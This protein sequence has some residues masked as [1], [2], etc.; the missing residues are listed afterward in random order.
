MKI[1][2]R[3][4]VV[5]CLLM[6]ICIGLVAC[7]GGECSHKWGDWSVT[8]N[9]TCIESGEKERKCSECGKTETSVIEAIGHDW[10]EATCTSPKT[11]KNCSATEGSA[12][13]HTYDQEV[14]KAEALKSEATCSSAAVYYKSCSCG[15]ISKSEADTFTSGSATAHTY[16]IEV[17]KAEALK[18]EATCSGAAVYYKSCSCGAISTSEADTF[19]SGSALNHSYAKISSTA[20][21]CDAPATETYRCSCG[22]E[23]TDTIGDALGHDIGGVASTEKQISGCEY[24]LMYK[25][26]R[27]G[28]GKKVE[29]EHIYRHS[30]VASITKAATCQS[31]GEKTLTCSSCG[32]SVKEAIA[33]DSTGHNWVKG[34]A[35][36][37]V[38]T[39]ECSYC[40]MTKNVAVY[41]GTKTDV[42]NAND[43]KNTEIEL[44]NANISLGDGVVD[45][46][47]DKNVTV[48]ADKLEGDDRNI[49]G[50]S[51]EQLSQVGNNPIYNFTINDGTENISQFGENNYVT[52]TLPYALSEGEDV[53]SIAVWF[54]G[55]R[56][57]E[58]I[59]ATYN[60]GYVT[61]KTNHFSYYTVTRLTPKE[62]CALYG[63]SYVDRHVDGSCTK[64]AY[65]LFVCVRCH[66]KYTDNLVEADG[67]DYVPDA[68]PATCTENGYTTYT[69]DDCGHS[70]T[71]RINATGH[72]WSVEESVDATCAQNGYTK[73]GCDNCEEEYTV[74]YDK[75]AHQFTDV[76]VPATCIKDGYTLH[77][78][79]NCD[80]SF[81]DTY[82]PAIGH[83][84]APYDWEWA[85]DYSSA[86]LTLVCENDDEHE[87][88]L[89]ASV[90]K[91]VVSGSCSS[92]VKTTFTATVTYDGKTYTDEKGMEEGTPSHNFSPE[93]KSNGEEHWHE[94][95]C[96]AKSDVSEHEF[97]NA[98]VT[99]APTCVSEG[100]STSY[101]EC[102]ETKVT[103]LPATNEHNYVDGICSVCGQE[104]EGCDHT[105]LH[106][107]SVD[108]GEIGACDFIF[109][110]ETCSCGEVKTFD[111]YTSI[112]PCKFGEPEMK[113]YT[114]ENGNN[115]MSMKQA[116]E[117][118]GLEVSATAVIKT[119]GCAMSGVMNCTFKLNG[120]VIIDNLVYE[121]N[122][123][124]HKDTELAVINLSDFGACP[125]AIVVYKCKD[126]G[127]VVDISDYKIGCDVDLTNL[128]TEEVKDENGV[129]HYVQKAECPKCGLTLV[130][131]RW[132]E[133]ISVCDR[134]SH[135]AI[136]VSY[137]ETIIIDLVDERRYSDHEYEYTYELN[138]DSCDDGYNVTEHCTRCGATYKSSSF[139]HQYEEFDIDLA[140]HGGCEGEIS[141]IRCEICKDLRMVHKMDI[142]CG[143][144]HLKP[145]EEEIE[146][147]GVIHHVSTTTCP[148]CGLKFVEGSWEIE[149]SV[150]VTVMYMAGQIYAGEL[151]IFEYN[152]SD[153][154]GGHEY[155][156][157]YE[158]DGESCD[159]G[160]TVT[161]HCPVC[162]KTEKYQS[163]GHT[164]ERRDISLR[165]LGLCGGEIIEEYCPVCDTVLSSEI[166]DWCKWEFKEENENGKLYQCHECGATKTELVTKSEKDEHCNYVRTEKCSYFVGGKEIFKYEHSYVMESH[167]YKYEFKM[168]GS[169]CEDG[170]TVIRTC[171]ACGE[172]Y[173]KTGNGHYIYN[174]FD[175]S[176]ESG[177]CDEHRL[178]VSVCP[179]GYEY[180]LYFGD[181]DFVEKNG[182]KAYS[183]DKC[184]L[185]ITYSVT[186]SEE[187]CT[188]TEAIALKVTHNG[189]EL[190]NGVNEKTYFNH[191]FADVEVSTID[192]KT[193][194]TT[195]CDKCNEISSTEVL[196]AALGEH[197][198]EYYY[199]Y[200]VTPSVTANYTIIG[201]ADRDTY[202]TLYRVESEPIEIG[203]DDDGGENAQFR[204]T[205]KLQAGTTYVYRI[206]F[207]D[208]GEGE[209]ISFAFFRGKSGEYSCKHDSYKEFS[210]L[211]EGST[212]CED[213][214]LSG[215][216]CAS[217]GMIYGM[218]TGKEHMTIVKD[219]IDLKNFGACYG[220]FIF[221]SCACGS[222]YDLG[223]DSCYDSRTTN[224]YYD[225]DGRLINVEVYTCSKCGLRISFSYYTVRDHQNCTLTYY[226]TLTINIGNE[227]VADKEYAVTKTEHD[228]M[229]TGTLKN[230]EGSSCEDGATISYKCRDCGHEESHEITDHETF[231]KE[232]IELSQ[233][234][235][236][237]GGYATVYTCA[238]GQRG[239][240]SIEHSLCEFDSRWCEPWI[241]NTIKGWRYT[242]DGNDYYDFD[243]CIYT[244]AVTD[245]TVCAFKIRRA[246][247]WLK[248]ENECRAYQYE[249]WQF[250]YGEGN[251]CLR[252][253]TFKTG[254]SRMYHNYTD[255]GDGDNIKLDCPDCGSY[256]YENREYNSDGE[257]TKYEKRISNTL[258][259]E[260]KKFYN[261]IAEYSFDEDGNFY[262][263]REYG[264]TIY[265]DDRVYWYEELRDKEAYTG[266]FGER[267]YKV[268][269]SHTD[270]D[271]DNY[272]EEYAYVMYKGYEYRIY[273]L[274]TRGENWERYDYAYSFQDGCVQTITYTSS[275]GENRTESKDICKFY[276]DVIVKEPTCSQEGEACLK[277]VV[278]GK[279]S[280]HYPIEPHN[281]NWIFVDENHYYCCFCGLE[282]KNGASGDIIMEDL[283][284]KYGNGENYV[285]GYYA[286]S[287]VEFTKYVSL[288]LADGRE[289]VLNDVEFTTIDGLRAFVFNKAAVEALASAKGYG[290][291]EYDVRFSFVPYG[292]DGS[293]DY[294][295]TFTE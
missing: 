37:G 193:Y 94:C 203:S 146:V 79:D 161:A 214:V 279:H 160:Y 211:P 122:E 140:E 255:S 138:G 97:E 283:T 271:N 243:A 38:R 81:T 130:A 89:D 242:I 233:L 166:H 15:A 69:C 145:V 13:A 151:L 207:F 93:W 119:D 280:E 58:S 76:T 281:H 114:D 120:K 155:E 55:D 40:H 83:A 286:N 267:G 235:S 288:I 165:E 61:F 154:Q 274:T 272:S 290:S 258:G 168:N 215:R 125:G 104:E 153:R 50:L 84:Y 164:Y 278:C 91:T 204:L 196:Q 266:P 33:K 259:G 257:C 59:K 75:T 7:D 177:C 128:Q 254:Y 45:S 63:H 262:V 98:T 163:K 27:E 115:C 57:P 29:G 236:V 252:E 51:E 176:H 222:R 142:G 28:C 17:V 174:E 212:S 101:C 253:V 210:V 202:V 44:N 269:Y 187:G 23:Y 224:E 276:T 32:D 141:V 31:D 206:R 108:F 221:Y 64:D 48:S 178:E 180:S 5:L 189:K 199:D 209:K 291:S 52:I 229:V 96:G 86:K 239:Y 136:K 66:D 74:I 247:Y 144:E 295:I 56:G 109:Y 294:A 41:E 26:K 36:S 200:T 25:C 184:G 156:Y 208:G 251:N 219:R 275:E 150:C 249:T 116:C 132:E 127:A 195:S 24:A 245:P 230:G 6:I 8:E 237:C 186:E 228:Y 284:K 179:C 240:L 232:R 205:H 72:I 234:G 103:A 148:K 147:D 185:Y 157:T 47:G 158:L 265:S 285:V 175:L 218:R 282:N 270:S 137:G 162:G 99:K 12:T 82:V 213:G 192:G 90:E 1:I 9:A 183:C 20:A 18:S 123:M 129:I 53:D 4:S 248:A 149:E 287:D 124:Y 225:D 223:L 172:K 190:Y 34:S 77:E 216:I 194:I 133:E 169:S 197:D 126:C 227:L 263:S 268:L 60:N 226:Y 181:F 11:C 238:C 167:N 152:L 42:T 70:Y 112:V 65:D 73:Y 62:R 14:V 293:F 54:I 277:C 39:D 80:Y 88:E 143:I 10:N 261:Y 256:Y 105:E 198:G 95:E 102:G 110:Y 273:T 2:N 43:L 220:E 67:H 118:C 292:S 22:D 188:L 171:E 159:D 244:C 134:F 289:V 100:E 19:T 260:Y 106:K 131:E 46:I 107:E 30:Y 170:Y 139:G 182:T 35:I 78:C 231:E 135:E 49:P 241:D 85:D 87:I 246:L 121:E 173:E 111:I 191:N 21:S 3:L 113:E 71:T 217:C 68:H 92:F 117:A 264:K 250:G 201:L 16:E